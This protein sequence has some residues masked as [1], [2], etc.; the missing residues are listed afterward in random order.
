[1]VIILSSFLVLQMSMNAS[2]THVK[3]TPPVTTYTAPMNANAPMDSN[4][5]TLL[6]VSVCEL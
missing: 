3:A 4:T 1:L 6:D 5:T 2:G